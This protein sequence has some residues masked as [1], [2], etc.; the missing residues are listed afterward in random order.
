[1]SLTHS[2]RIPLVMSSVSFIRS[3]FPFLATCADVPSFQTEVY[4]S[5]S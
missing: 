4:V 5:F 3:S 1:M 2:F